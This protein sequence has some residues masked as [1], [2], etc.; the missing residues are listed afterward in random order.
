MSFALLVAGTTHETPQQ[1]VTKYNNYKAICNGMGFE[2]MRCKG[3]EN[4]LSI[5]FD[6]SF[7]M[8]KRIVTI[9]NQVPHDLIDC[10]ESSQ[11]FTFL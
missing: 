11:F 8:I 5:S 10:A 6:L 7:Y 1:V 4:I 3:S 9:Y 2:N